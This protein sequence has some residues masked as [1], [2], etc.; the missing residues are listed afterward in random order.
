MLRHSPY[1]LLGSRLSPAGPR[2][3]LSI[4]I[5]HRVLPET[6]PLFPRE[7]TAASFDTHM[8]MLKSVFNVLPLADAVARL[9]H[10]NLPAR[11]ASITFD[12]GYADNVTHALPILKKHGLHA[13][14]FIATGYLDGGRM[15]NDTVI[16]AV[17]QSRQETLDL[18]DLGLG[19]HPL[20]GAAARASAIRRILPQVKYLP[21]DA[22]EGVAA[23][24]AARAGVEA[25]PDDLMMTTAQLKALHGA[26]M[27][28]GGHTCR[29]P[30]LARLDAGAARD[31]IVAGKRWL[32]D[33]LG[34]RVRLFAYPNGK[35]QADYLPAQAELVRELGF[36]AA[37]ST[38]RGV[39]TL[40]HDVFQLPRF[41]PW[42]TGRNAFALRLLQN[43]QQAQPTA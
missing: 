41:T 7:P 8:A 2:G 3:R 12:D 16:E 34:S 27:E 36:D 22:R 37:V 35:P 40:G 23:A 11:A 17:R 15:F 9:K 19:T 42:D 6:D 5:Y 20:A 24:I 29:H 1:R 32:E 43:L 14:F 10:G 39:S 28:I 33:T 25:L 21:P 13:T 31:E 26:G 30:I 4:L 38:A 18:A